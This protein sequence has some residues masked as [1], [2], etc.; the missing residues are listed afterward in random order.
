[1][2]VGK[3]THVFLL[4]FA[5]AFDKVPHVHLCHTQVKSIR[6]Q[7]L[8]FRDFLVGRTQQVIVNGKKKLCL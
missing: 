4:D 5:K 3:Q 8:C 2:N 6:D 1:M 7:R